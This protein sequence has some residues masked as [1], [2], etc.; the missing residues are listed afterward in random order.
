LSEINA[1]VAQ[2]YRH[3]I[4]IWDGNTREDLFPYFSS[5]PK[6]KNSSFR[7]RKSDLKELG[8]LEGRRH[9]IARS[10]DLYVVDG[11]EITTCWRDKVFH[12]HGY[13]WEEAFG[14]NSRQDITFIQISV[15]CDCGSFAFD[16][17]GDT[18]LVEKFPN[19]PQVREIAQKLAFWQLQFE[20]LG[21]YSE[22][23]D[24]IN[25]DDFNGRGLSLA[26]HLKVILG[27]RAIVAYQKPA[28]DPSPYLH[29]L[30]F[31]QMSN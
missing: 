16:G 30:I 28:E 17:H 24:D 9:V 15:C 5:H 12:R 23:Q 31:L 25:F 1:V 18:R 13:Y 29:H 20:N 7:F 8:I 3:A 14:D 2:D 22:R 26:K 6:Y 19:W 21:C 10:T 27:E 4:K 11:E